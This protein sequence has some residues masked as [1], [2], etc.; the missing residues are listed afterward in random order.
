MTI[1]RP[2]HN[3]DNKGKL[4]VTVFAFATACM[5][6]TNNSKPGYAH[7]PARKLVYRDSKA[8]STRFVP[9]NCTSAFEH[10]SVS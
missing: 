3:T 4:F 5:T 2:K 6:N 7:L 9:R 8:A 1:N 10:I